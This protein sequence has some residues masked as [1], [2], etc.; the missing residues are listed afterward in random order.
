MRTVTFAD[1]AEQAQQEQ[2]DWLHHIHEQSRVQTELLRT[3]ARHTGLLYVL[4]IF[5]LVCFGIY[6]LAVLFG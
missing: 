5:G 2:L 3:I 6:V 4:A 1:R